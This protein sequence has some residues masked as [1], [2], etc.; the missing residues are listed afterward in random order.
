MPAPT[1]RTG[2]S[3]RGR[4]VGCEQP[5]TV[6][7]CFAGRE[8]EMDVV[9]KAVEECARAAKRAAPSLATASEQAID[10]ALFS[11]AERLLTHREEVLEANRADVAKAREEGMSAGL[12]DRLTIT[13]ERLTGMAGQLRLLAGAPHQD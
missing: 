4:W 12:L 13:E 11:M 10:A 9:A 2:L 7:R 1:A 6:T 8:S 3:A 5:A